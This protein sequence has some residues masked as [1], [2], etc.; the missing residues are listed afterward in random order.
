MAK[1]SGGSEK[2]ITEVYGGPTKRFFVSM[3][4]RDIELDDAILDLLDNCVDGAM[5]MNPSKAYSPSPFK[6]YWADLTLSDEG[7]RIKDNCGGIPRDYLV[8]AFSLGRPT[9]ERDKGL[10]TIGM[11]GIGMKRAIFK[12]GRSATVTSHN[13]TANVMVKYT[14]EWLKP[15]N[16]EWELPVE[17]K[18]ATKRDFG[19]TINVAK[20]KEDISDQLGNDHF[21]NKLVNKIGEHFGYIMQKGFEV[22]INGIPVPA[23]TLPLLSSKF[24]RESAIRP[25]DYIG[26]I[27][28]VHVKV[29]I[30]LFRGLVQE[31]E[32][33]E[34]SQGATSYE[35][36]GIS[37]VC[38]DRVVLLHDRS[39][40]TGWGDGG[41]PRYHPQFRAIAGLVVLFSSDP[42][43]L[44]ISTTKRDLDAGSDIYLKVRQICMEGIKIFT[45]FTNRWKGMENEASEF[46]ES[47]QK[48]DARTQINLAANHGSSIRGGGDAKKYRPTLPIPVNK[49]PRRRVSFLRDVSEI[50]EVSVFLYDEKGQ[51]PS[52]VGAGSF[53]RVLKEARDGRRR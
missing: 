9:V 32:I 42:L 22:Y 35:R 27:D 16:D 19:V 53:E 8:N 5:R 20:L 46:F 50:Q 21:I 10:P 25:F 47:T 4:T 34:E 43:K 13:A 31:R 23:V 14:E 41:V 29:T 18:P 38:N 24:S 11:Y 51:H 49:T 39:I 30:G 52:V 12:M 17:E 44:P 28:D 45:D 2:A 6:G 3:L 7:F 40:K 37:V 48:A 33:E 1:P 26:K 15:D 36:A